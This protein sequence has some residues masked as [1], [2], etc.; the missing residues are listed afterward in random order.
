MWYPLL[1]SA[2]LRRTLSPQIVTMVDTATTERVDELRREINHHNYRYHVLSDPVISDAQYDALM[3][4]LQALEQQHPEL[5]TPDSPTQR[6]GAAPADGFA[7]VRHPVP[8]LS[9]GNAFN[10]E[11]LLA[12]HRRAQELLDGSTFE[13]VCELKIDGLAVA[14]TYEDGRLVL[15]ATRGDGLRGEDVTL[16]LRTIRSIPLVVTGD[17][18]PRRFEVRGEVYFPRSSFQRMNEERIAQGE[19]PYANPRNTA[20]GSLRQL[21]PSATAARPLDIFVYAL[22][23]AED[24][25]MPANHWE[26]LE[27]LKALGFKT[28]PANALCH[29]LEEVEEYYQEWLEEKEQLDYGVDGVVV[30]VNPFSYQQHLG[31]VGREPRWAIARKFPATQAVTRL[32]DIGINVGRTGSLNP[33]AVL[34]P[35]NVGGATVKMA[36]LHNED[37]IRRKD[38]RIGDWV[39]VERAGEVI[40]QVVAPIV[41]RRTGQ[42]REFSMPER[43]P[44]C[45]EP[46]IR[47]EREAMTYCINSACS[48]QFARLLMHFVGRGAM[49]I[50][51]I[52]EKLALSLLEARL[53]EDIGDIYSITKEHLVSLERMAEKSA[54][55]ILNAIEHSKSRPVPNVLTALGILHVGLE[56]AEALVRR[57]GS[58]DKLAEA[59]EE[60]LAA[61][62]GIGPKI[63]ESIVSHFRQEGNRHVLDKLRRAG[64]RLEAE[65]M[66][67]EARSLPLAGMQMVVTG[68]LSSM[69]R[70]QAEGRIKELGGSAGSSVSK[71]T[72]YLVAGVDPGSKLDQAQKLGTPILDEEE[73]MKLLEGGAGAAAEKF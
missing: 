45:G 49:D 39:T 52:G 42:E 24:G 18:V 54:T 58:L 62:P 35:V 43:C 23:H 61:V 66:A 31:V 71:K 7:E 44:A 57:F 47:P 32:L 11:E 12:W 68:R 34:E 63:A 40:P 25:N 59:T 51:G 64:V 70:S 46:V 67:E 19:P 53:V 37:D 1:Y 21:D 13:M 36:T 3:R 30:K 14:L 15:G 6:V 69:S 29:T 48:A 26:T 33:Y 10:A 16:N 17:Q 5:V 41:A 28:N 20:A 22:G 60:E 56:T 55:N 27:R 9:L 8:L 73:F 4:E 2:I 38:I 65:A 72:A 50:E